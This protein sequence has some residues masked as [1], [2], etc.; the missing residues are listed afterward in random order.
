M[1]ELYQDALVDLLAPKNKKP[2]KL[3]IKKDTKVSTIDT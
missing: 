1:L 3:D 2:L